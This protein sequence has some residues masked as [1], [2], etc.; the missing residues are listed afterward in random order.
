MIE[1]EKDTRRSRRGERVSVTYPRVEPGR[2]GDESSVQERENSL[3]NLMDQNIQQPLRGLG[4]GWVP[5]TRPSAR[6]T[7]VD[8]VPLEL[9]QCLCCL[10]DEI[11]SCGFDGQAGLLG[12]VRE[13]EWM[14]SP[15]G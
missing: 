7:A 9:F 4:G 12:G 2:K 5:H 13:R 6:S 15:L 8:A 1:M 10:S 3:T 11:G 14:H